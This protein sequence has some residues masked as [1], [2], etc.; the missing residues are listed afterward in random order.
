[1][2][3]YQESFAVIGVLSLAVWLVLFGIAVGREQYWG[4][5]PAVMVGMSTLIIIFP[6]KV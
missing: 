3:K 5:L 4:F 6:G 2:N 1:M